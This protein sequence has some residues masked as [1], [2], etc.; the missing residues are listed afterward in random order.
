MNLLM[1]LF[2]I[3]FISDIYLMFAMLWICRP[4]CTALVPEN[5]RYSEELI[6]TRDHVNNFAFNCF[7]KVHFFY[8]MIVIHCSQSFFVFM[9][10]CIFSLLPCFVTCIKHANADSIWM[11]YFLICTAIW[12]C[13]WILFLHITLQCNHHQYCRC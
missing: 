7:V 8:L 2:K 6:P 3:V 13:I 10:R 11:I 1:L 12:F 5:P 9:V 4:I